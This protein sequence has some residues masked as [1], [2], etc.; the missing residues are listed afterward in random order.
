[1]RFKQKGILFWECQLGVTATLVICIALIFFDR[2]LFPVFSVLSV[3]LVL[4]LFLQPL[5]TK[6]V[7]TI[8]ETGII[9]QE[10]SFV[11]WEYNWEEI[12]ELQ[13]AHQFRNPCVK[14]ILKSNSCQNGEENTRAWFQLGY[15]AKKAINQFCQCPIVW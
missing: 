15:S 9:C 14:I 8:N 5:H 13:V 11:I 7:I 12:R 1:M 4:C 10:A 2:S 6:N 3:L